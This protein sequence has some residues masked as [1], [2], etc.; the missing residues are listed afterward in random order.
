MQWFLNALNGLG[1]ELLKRPSSL[2]YRSYFYL[3]FG[4]N[5]ILGYPR[6]ILINLAALYV[7][8]VELFPTIRA[9]TVQLTVIGFISVAAM[10]L[11]SILGGWIYIKKTRFWSTE[12]DVSIEANPYNFKAP[13][14]YYREVILPSLLHIMTK[15]PVRNTLLE[16]RLRALIRGESVGKRIETF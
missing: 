10:L 7:V 14:G 13:P 2:F 11:V 6:Q 9:N 3:K 8:L 1:E 16:D 4:Y 5:S 12:I 15:Q